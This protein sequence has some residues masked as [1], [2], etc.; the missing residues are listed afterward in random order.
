MRL[1][2]PLLDA[3]LLSG[4]TGEALGALPSQAPANTE[5]FVAFELCS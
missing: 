4:V 2:S 3:S 1:A 5:T